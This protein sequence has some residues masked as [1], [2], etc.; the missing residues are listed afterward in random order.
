[1]SMSERLSLARSST[2]RNQLR[3]E[4]TSRSATM[5][6]AGLVSLLPLPCLLVVALLAQAWNHRSHPVPTSTTSTPAVVVGSTADDKYTVELRQELKALLLR[7]RDLPRAEREQA[8]Y[9]AA[10]KRWQNSMD[11]NL[12][13]RRLARMRSWPDFLVRSVEQRNSGFVTVLIHCD[14]DYMRV[15]LLNTPDGWKVAGLVK[16]F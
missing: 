10:W 12:V 1:M 3:L 5:R 7:Y 6:R 15:W 14:D 9:P 8:T 4:R 13:A 16:P 2:S 11:G